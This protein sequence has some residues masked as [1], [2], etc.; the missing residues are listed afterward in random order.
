MVSAVTNM[1]VTV[2]FFKGS[3]LLNHLYIHVF[4]RL[5]GVMFQKTVIFIVML[6][7]F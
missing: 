7:S 5:H 6:I 4:T 3:R 2:F 1:K